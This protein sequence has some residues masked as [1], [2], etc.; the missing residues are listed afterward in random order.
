MVIQRGKHLLKINLKKYE[1]PK[2]HQQIAR[3]NIKLNDKDLDEKVAKKLNNPYYFIDEK[4][5]IDLKVNLESHNANHAI[6]LLNDISNFPDIGIE[7][8]YG[9]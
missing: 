1:T 3:Q 5:K 4:L 9:N 6:S 8:K 2:K 7:T